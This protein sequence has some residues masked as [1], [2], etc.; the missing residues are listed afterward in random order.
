MNEIGVEDIRSNRCEQICLD[1]KWLIATVDLTFLQVHSFEAHT[2][3]IRSIA[4]HPSQPYLL[5]SSGEGVRPT[6]RSDCTHFGVCLSFF[7]VKSARSK[8]VRAHMCVCVCVCMCV[9]VRVCVRTCVY[10]HVHA[11]VCVRV[12]TCACV[13]ACQLTRTCCLVT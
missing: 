6:S 5:S 7:L 2:D 10:V 8:R 9:C 1:V 13:H 3:Y 11:L 12:C 4:V